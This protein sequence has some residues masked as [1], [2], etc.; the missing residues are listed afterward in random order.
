[1]YSEEIDYDKKYLNKLSEAF[2]AYLLVFFP[3]ILNHSLILK[4][5]CFP[6]SYSTNF[7]IQ[8]LSIQL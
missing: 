7:K 3:F 8:L 1:M 2:D 4:K 6:E 5:K